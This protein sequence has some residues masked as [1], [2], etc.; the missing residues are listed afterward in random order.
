MVSPAVIVLFVH[1]GADKD[2][3]IPFVV[4]SAHVGNG[5]ENE[6]LPVRYECGKAVVISA[7][8][9]ELPTM[10]ATHSAKIIDIFRLKRFIIFPCIATGRKFEIDIFF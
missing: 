7:H 1:S 4:L 3:I 10:I 8:V 2:M 6:F 9:D 5:K